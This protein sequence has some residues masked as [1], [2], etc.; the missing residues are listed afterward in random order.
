[1]KRRELYI[2]ALA[3]GALA[4]GGVAGVAFSAGVGNG[5]DRL[6][7]M[8]RKAFAARIGTGFTARA[9]TEGADRALRLDTVESDGH[10]QSFFARFRG[11]DDPAEDLYLLRAADGETV[12]LHLQPSLSEPGVLEA[13]VNPGHL[14]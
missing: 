8:S 11:G 9:M 12:M 6:A 10:G 7:T 1:M 2:G 3:G 4:S 5:H 14:G 13:I